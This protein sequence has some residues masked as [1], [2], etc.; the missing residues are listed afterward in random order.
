MSVAGCYARLHK[1]IEIGMI[2]KETAWSFI[3]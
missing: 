2:K 3:S 1:S